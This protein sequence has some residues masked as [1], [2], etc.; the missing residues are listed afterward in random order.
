[1][2]VVNINIVMIIN[3]RAKLIFNLLI[4]IFGFNLHIIVMRYT[5]VESSAVCENDLQPEGCPHN[6]CAI[7]LQSRGAVQSN[8]GDRRKRRRGNV[9][10][11]FYT[12]E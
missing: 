2:H 11:I 6:N 8:E 3:Y 7:D 5:Q 1:M 9:F 12:Y 4:D 10:F